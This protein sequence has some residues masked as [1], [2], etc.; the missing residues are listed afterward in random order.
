MYAYRDVRTRLLRKIDRVYRTA[1][2]PMKTGSRAVLTDVRRLSLKPRSVDCAITSPPY[3]YDLDYGRDNRLRL[4]FLGVDDYGA[5]DHGVRSIARFRVLMEDTFRQLRTCM[6]PGSP[7]VM[8]V[9]DA[10]RRGEI[11]HTPAVI[12]E[13]ACDIVGG[14]SRVRVQRQK[15]RF[16]KRMAVH[17][18]RRKHEWLVELRRD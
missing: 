11:V 18:R 5:L 3:M 9:G 2:I 6:K 16:I 14:F 13:V 1:R 15:F 10:I 12:S 8:V 17:P 7:C 4:W